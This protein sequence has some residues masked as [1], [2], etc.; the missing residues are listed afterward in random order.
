MHDGWSRHE[1]QLNKYGDLEDGP[2]PHQDSHFYYTHNLLPS[3]QFW[4]PIPLL[5][6]KAES[7]VRH[8]APLLF[9]RTCRA[10]FRIGSSVSG[11]W[12]LCVPIRHTNGAW[13]GILRIPNKETLDSI[14]ME[15]VGTVLESRPLEFIA[16]SRGY[17]DGSRKEEPGLDEWLLEERPATKGLYEFYNVMWIEWENG[18][19]YRR[20]VGRILRDV[21]EGQN[22][23]WVDVTLG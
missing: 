17:A 9:T 20:A 1:H 12:F 4:Y 10:W 2:A 5:D 7:I 21:W 15:Q 13:A 14:R 19:A 23:E 6:Q 16:L 18:I 22:L 11:V 3:R 8:P